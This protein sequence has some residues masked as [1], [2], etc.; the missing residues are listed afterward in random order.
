VVRDTARDH[1]AH[2]AGKLV[3][4]ATVVFKRCNSSTRKWSVSSV[5]RLVFQIRLTSLFWAPG[6]LV[7]TGLGASSVFQPSDLTV[8]NDAEGSWQ[9][10]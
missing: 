3:V 5:C 9:K 10:T 7:L 2:K 4:D 8:N 1:G 6:T